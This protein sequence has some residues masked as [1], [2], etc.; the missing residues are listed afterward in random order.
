MSGDAE[1]ASDPAR[2]LLMIGPFPPPVHGLAVVTEAMAAALAPRR[3]VRRV[4]LAVG[5]MPPAGPAALA[6]HARRLAR[7][8]RALGVLLPFRLAGGREVYQACSGGL[9][10]AYE[11]LLL[12]A[13]RALGIHATVHHHSFHYIDRRSF[14]MAALVRAGGPGM[15]HIFLCERMR[16]AF[17]AVYGPTRARILPND[18]FIAPT[19]RPAPTTAPATAHNPLRIGFLSNLTAEKG[20]PDFLALVRAAEGL[21]AGVLAGPAAGADL[22]GIEAARRD[23]GPA[24]DYRG[25]VHGADKARFLADIDVFVFPTGYAHE[26]Q[27]LVIAEAMA[28]GLPVLAYDRGC[29]AGQLGDI[30][31]P[32]ERSGDFTPWALA[33]L[34]R[35]AADPTALAETGAANAARAAA[36]A[37]EG[38]RVIAEIAEP[39]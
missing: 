17:E 12:A 1:G 35:F 33:H 13:A 4:N 20:L 5:R 23:L 27:P 10:L 34:R 3:P 18:A 29:I 11:A 25:P 14:L 31:P 26:A 22:D 30:L 21:A 16:E 32:L 9:G 39:V 6:Y 37:A 38:R 19:P 28:A 2:P 24:L 36:R 8:A 15:T 7:V